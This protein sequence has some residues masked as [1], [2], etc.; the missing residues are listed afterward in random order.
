MKLLSSSNKMFTFLHFMKTIDSLNEY[1]YLNALQSE[2]W[3]YSTYYWKMTKNPR[4]SQPIKFSDEQTENGGRLDHTFTA[5]S[6]IYYDWCPFLQKNTTCARNTIACFLQECQPH[7]ARFTLTFPLET[8]RCLIG[9][10]NNLIDVTGVVIRW[11][12]CCSITVVAEMMQQYWTCSLLW[13]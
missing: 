3:I 11:Q 6:N 4:K 10:A 8:N 12:S 13:V 9:I 7:K 2:C 1:C 5:C